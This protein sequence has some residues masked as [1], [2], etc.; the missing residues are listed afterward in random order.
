LND[1]DIDSMSEVANEISTFESEALCV[2][3]DVSKYNDAER[4]VRFAIEKFG[5]VDILVN[6]AGVIIRKQAEEF[7][8]PELDKV[9]DLNLK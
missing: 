5:R 7:T 3:G 6:S 9:I 4:V 1:I 8:D 2:Q